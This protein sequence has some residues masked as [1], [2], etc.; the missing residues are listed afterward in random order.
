MSAIVRRRSLL[1]LV[2]VCAA[3][4]PV[5]LLAQADRAGMTAD[6]LYRAACAACHGADGKGQPQSAVGFDTPLPD[7]T[8][9]AF[10]TPEADLDWLSVIHRGGRIRGLDRRM[11]AFGDSLSE[12]E[13][14]R[15]VDYLRGFCTEPAWPRGELNFPRPFFTEKAFP[16]NEAVATVAIEG[17][18]ETALGMDFLFEQRLGKRAQYE[19]NVPLAFHQDVAGAWSRG[20]GD[21]NLAVK[22]ALFDNLAH[23]AIVSA[24]GEVTLPTGRE[25]VG[26]GGGVAIF[27]GFGMVGQALPAAGFVQ[28]HA[29]FEVPANA[30]IASKEVYWRTAVGRTFTPGRWGRAWSPIVEILGAKAVG[31][32]T[33]WDIV[34]QLQVSLSG[35]QHVLVN[36]G[37]RIP[38]KQPESRSNTLMMYLLWDWFDGGLTSN[39]RRR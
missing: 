38:V 30:D 32:P 23:G 8:D 22:Y 15:L 26:L 27:E 19:I 9:C 16:E 14:A 33:D 36:V 11:P 12:A 37:V 5:R 6:Q 7:F 2:V 17:G 21:V 28:V 4:A 29:G 31:A 3:A 39:W 34:P 25:S 13:I 10:T 1:A 18:P 24:G 35:L 20:V